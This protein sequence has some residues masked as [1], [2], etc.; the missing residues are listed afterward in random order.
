MFTIIQR[1]RHRQNATYT[2]KKRSDTNR[3]PSTACGGE[4]AVADQ[5]FVRTSANVDEPMVVTAACKS[6]AWRKNFELPGVHASPPSGGR[7]FPGVPR[8]YPPG[9]ASV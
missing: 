8:K 6:R 9:F 2:D 5:N 1:S 4:V 3:F 7:C